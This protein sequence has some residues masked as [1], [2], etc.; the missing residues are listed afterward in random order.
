MAYARTLRTA[1]ICPHLYTCL[2][3]GLCPSTLSGGIQTRQTQQVRAVSC[4][5]TT[6]VSRSPD[7]VRRGAEPSKAGS[8]CIC[9]TPGRWHSAEECD[10]RDMCTRR[11]ASGVAHSFHPPITNRR[12]EL[13]LTDLWISSSEPARNSERSS[14]AHRAT[15]ITRSTSHVSL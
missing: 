13:R 15:K 8:F 10:R 7:V 1:T 3:D 11:P 6:N 14:R 12:N 4:G 2:M 5:V 9:T